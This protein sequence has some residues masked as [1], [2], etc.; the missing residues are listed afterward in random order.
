MNKPN[1]SANNPNRCGFLP[2]TKPT[3]TRRR[4]L[5]NSGSVLGASAIAALDMERFA[6]AAGSDILRLG[7]IGCGGRGLGAAAQILKTGP[8]IQ[9]VAMGDVFEDRMKSAL[10]NLQSLPEKQ[11]DV[12][13]DRQFIGFDAYRKVLDSGVDLV[14]LATPPG[15]RPLHFEAAVNAGKH[16][17]LE[18][19]IAVDAP[20][21]RRLLRANQTA[22]QKGLSAVVGYQRRFHPAYQAMVAK[23]QEGAIGE[24]SRL[25]AYWRQSTQ[26]WVKKRAVLEAKLRRQL[27]EM[28]FQLQDWIHF[29]WLSGDLMVEMLTNCID[30]CNW[31]MPGPPQSVRATSER[32]QWLTSEYGD[33]SDLF[34]AEYTFANGATMA[35]DICLRKGKVSGIDQIAHGTKGDA[36]GE[37][38]LIADPAG[39]LIWTNEGAPPVDPSQ[40]EQDLFI[41]S[42]RNGKPLNMIEDAVNT[43]LT[44]IMGRTAAAQKR[45]VT[46]DEMLASKESFFPDEPLTWETAPPTLPDKEGLYQTPAHGRNG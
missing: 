13:P 29:T 25:E 31:I 24:I 9:L 4:F 20:G 39:H 10:T 23:I 41:A 42:I 30:V 43:D 34:S 3:L 14:I 2:S 33:N 45:V 12:I 35:A 26:V 7:L 15:F 11:T 40:R 5:R 21:A 18:K 17:F 28:E 16:C 8:G 19:P 46:W 36:T 22:Q 6:H 37:K 32:K 44:A 38:H 1:L 27:T